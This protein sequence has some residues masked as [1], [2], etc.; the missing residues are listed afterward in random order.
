MKNLDINLSDDSL[1]TEEI[2]K[3]L[4]DWFKVV[5]FFSLRQLV[6]NV[7]ETLVILDRLVK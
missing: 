6:A 2:D 1:K 5:L 7:V 3:M 4:K